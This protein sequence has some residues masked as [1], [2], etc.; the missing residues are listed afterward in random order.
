MPRKLT[1]DERAAAWTARIILALVIAL[2]VLYV[3]TPDP[4]PSLHDYLTGRAVL[5]TDGRPQ[6]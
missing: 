1:D 5:T 3:T 2:A 6:R 4:E